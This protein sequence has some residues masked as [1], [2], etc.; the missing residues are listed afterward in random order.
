MHGNEKQKA[1]NMGNGSRH[2]FGKCLG[3]GHGK[4]FSQVNMCKLWFLDFSH[5][6]GLFYRKCSSRINR[7]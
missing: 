6:T 1:T 3:H 7:W 5:K 4:R 2:R